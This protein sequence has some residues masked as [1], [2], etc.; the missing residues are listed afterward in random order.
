MNDEDNGLVNTDWRST[1]DERQLKEIDFNLVYHE[2][3]SHGT[4]GHNLRKICAL[5]AL[6]LNTYTAKLA[7]YQE[8][9]DDF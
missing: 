1:F 8:R 2:E 9:R 3:F 4:D 5:M 6:L 7:E